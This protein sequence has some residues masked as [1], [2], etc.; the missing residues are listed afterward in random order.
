[1]IAD[2][3]RLLGCNFIDPDRQGAR[4][5][6]FSAFAG[7]PASTRRRAST[8][9]ASVRSNPTVGSSPRATAQAAT[10]TRMA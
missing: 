1:V 4:S 8:T 9:D 7:S 10:R 3:L 5:I 6:S 2:E